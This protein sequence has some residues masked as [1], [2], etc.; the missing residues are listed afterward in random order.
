MAKPMKIKI[1]GI[2]NIDDARTACSFGADALGFVFYPKSPRYITKER[3]REIIAMLPPFVVKVGVFAGTSADEVEEI[4]H[5]SG[6]SLAQIHDEMLL[7]ASFTIPIIKAF[8]ISS[9]KDLLI[10]QHAGFCLVDSFVAGYGGE[11]KRLPLEWFRGI[12]CEEIILAGGIS[13]ENINEIASFGFYGVDVSSSIESKKGYKDHVKM[14]R[15][16]SNVKSL[17]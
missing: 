2:T 14:E 15:L 13:N 16:I 1:C 7:D 3:A 8:R 5:A 4:Y 12:K 17:R 9:Q 6:L 10:A 11:G